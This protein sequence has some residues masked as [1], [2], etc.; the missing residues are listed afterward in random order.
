MIRSFDDSSGEDSP[1]FNPR[2]LMSSLERHLGQ[3]GRTAN[4]HADAAQQLVYDAWEAATDEEEENLIFSALKLDATNVDALL[5]SA[6]YAGLDGAEEIEFLRKVVAIGEKNLG[7][8]SFKEFAGQ[9]WS[10]IETRPYM[11]ARERLAAAL[12]ASGRLDDAITEWQAMLELN[13]GDNQGVRYSLLPALLSVKR[14]EA[15]RGLFEKYPEECEFNTV[16]AWCRV[17]ERFL[18]GDLPGAQTSLAVARKQNPATQAYV[19]GHR[20]VPK[21]LPPAYAPGSREEAI[22]FAETLRKMWEKH[23]AALKW[24]EAQKMK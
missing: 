14:M 1:K 3:S 7:P 12:R 17:L 16:F 8:K 18:S 22:C 6:L 20:G 9:F 15:A 24:L 13:P 2:A 23:P 4:K 11:R 21:Q 10:F 5:Q 19:K